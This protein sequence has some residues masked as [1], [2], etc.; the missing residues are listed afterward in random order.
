MPDTFQQHA[1]Q[2]VHWCGDCET[3]TPLEDNSGP[4]AMYCTR[5]MGGYRY[6]R[7]RLMYVCIGCLCAYFKEEDYKEHTCHECY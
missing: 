7:K 6:P 2:L 3:W 1:R 4:C 5:L